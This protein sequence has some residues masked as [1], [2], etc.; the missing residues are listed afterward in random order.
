LE[1]HLDKLPRTRA[2]LDSVKESDRDFR[3]RRI[4]WA[5]QELEKEGQELKEW[6]ILRKAGI[7]KE[8]E[9]YIEIELENLIVQE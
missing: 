5:I 2:Y 3:I 8:Y 1:K 7:R 9:K 4:K 6:R